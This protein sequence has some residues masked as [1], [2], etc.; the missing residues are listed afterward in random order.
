VG[1]ACSRQCLEVWSDILDRSS[2]LGSQEHSSTTDRTCGNIVLLL[3]LFDVLAVIVRT[4]PT[5]HR[6]LLLPGS[7]VVASRSGRE[8]MTTV[9]LDDAPGSVTNPGGD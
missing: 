2:S 6:V 1:L 8:L 7:I 3:L 5:T 9:L 4:L